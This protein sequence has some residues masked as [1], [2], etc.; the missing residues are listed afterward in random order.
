[1][2]ICNKDGKKLQQRLDF[3]GNIP[4]LQ[5]SQDRELTLGFN[6]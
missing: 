6:Y 1:M 5:V 4:V 2:C 3:E